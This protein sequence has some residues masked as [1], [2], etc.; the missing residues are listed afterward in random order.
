MDRTILHVDM[1]AFF[2][3]V[4]V[5]DNPELNGVPV[6]V[7]GTGKRGVVASCNYEARLFGV[8]S[9]VA[10]ATAR[11]LC[12]N[13]VFIDGRYSRY[14]EV[15]AK[16]Y[17]LLTTV[18]PVVER[19][20]LDEAFLDIGGATRLFGAPIEIAARL[21]ESVLEELGLNCSVGVG[22]SKMIA[23]LASKA[24]KPHL[25]QRGVEVGDGVLVVEDSSERSF[26]DPLPV[27]WLWGVGAVTRKR[28]SELGVKTVGDLAQIPESILI[29]EFGSSHGT[30]LALLS[31]GIDESPVVAS[32]PPKSIGRE[33]TFAQD[34]CDIEY[35]K[36]RL[37][38]LSAGVS[39]Q[40][41]EAGLS[42][43]RVSV[44]V[45]L[46]DLTFQTRSF[47]L[48]TSLDTGPAISAVAQ[49]LLD[50]LPIDRG[51]RLLG[52]STSN[53]CDVERA[54]QLSL[55]SMLHD[56]G[57]RKVDSSEG[58]DLQEQAAVL[59]DGWREIVKAVDAIRAKFGYGA[60]GN[61]STLTGLGLP[62]TA[63]RDAPWG[64]SGQDP[65]D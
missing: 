27:S 6:V 63:R 35:L 55:L 21:R 2:A 15:S 62:S 30:H 39:S 51:I 14:V 5:L 24:A 11:R 43:S 65:G 47:T 37:N 25:T 26:L 52:V 58:E 33:V 61:T 34:S 49:A 32:R 22:R 17:E 4:E 60:V 7:G 23:K 13:A 64:P 59:E 20:G 9:A 3:A 42:A 53:F 19:I 50:S 38:V 31:K 54:E 40:L 45:R 44:K 10:M 12:P 8:R 18:S 56:D 29:R 41:R 57:V 16:L 36:Q 48:S 28:L 46:A 1:D